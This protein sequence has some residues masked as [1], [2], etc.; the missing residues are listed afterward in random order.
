M[1]DSRPFE[2]ALFDGLRVIEASVMPAVT[3]TNTNAPTVMIVE[4]GAAMIK[5]RHA[6]K[7]GA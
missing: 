7:N 3:S 5:R 4:K 1:A 2:P 6:A